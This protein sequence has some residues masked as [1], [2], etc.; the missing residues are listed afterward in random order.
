MN[1]GQGEKP[2]SPHA[3]AVLATIGLLSSVVVQTI[4]AVYN[5]GVFHVQADQ[6]IGDQ[7]HHGRRE[8]TNHLET[9]QCR[10][11]QRPDD[12]KNSPYF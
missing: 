12:V 10:I 9:R 7:R 3:W 4:V 2:R 6:G 5:H 11:C 1:D 8:N